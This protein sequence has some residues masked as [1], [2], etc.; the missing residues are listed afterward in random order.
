LTVVEW[1]ALDKKLVLHAVLAGTLVTALSA[2]YSR[3]VQPESYLAPGYSQMIQAG[4]IAAVR[5]GLPAPW[6]LRVVT[7]LGPI[8][9]DSLR[10]LTQPKFLVIGFLID[11]LIWSAAGLF[12]V[13][14]SGRLRKSLNCFHDKALA[15]LGSESCNLFH[16]CVYCS[17]LIRG[18]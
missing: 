6:L 11:I 18:I 5:H 9:P 13:L 17:Q 7:V 14:A 4:F 8:P 3:T 15:Y 2:T 1:L 16:S 12:A 10:M